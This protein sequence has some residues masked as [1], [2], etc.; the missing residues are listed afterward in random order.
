S[1]SMILIIVIFLEIFLMLHSTFPM[2]ILRFKHTLVLKNTIYIL[3]FC[4][5]SKELSLDGCSPGAGFIKV[6]LGYFRA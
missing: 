1:E 2:V 3:G 4:M 6:N 5:D